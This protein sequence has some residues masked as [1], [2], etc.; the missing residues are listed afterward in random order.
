MLKSMES[1]FTS[2]NRFH[3]LCRS[4]ASG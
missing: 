1:L 2:I 4:S 3:P